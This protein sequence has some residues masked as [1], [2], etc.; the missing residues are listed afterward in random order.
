MAALGKVLKERGELKQ[1]LNGSEAETE[2]NG[3][4]SKINRLTS[5][6]KPT[7]PGHELLRH[8]IEKNSEYES[9]RTTSQFT[10]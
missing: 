1:E 5:L 9:S 6:E 10:I 7:A 8:E 2:G 3:N 4:I